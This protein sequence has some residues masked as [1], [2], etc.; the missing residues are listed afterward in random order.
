[1]S[2]FKNISQAIK[3]KEIEIVFTEGTDVRILAA[4]RKLRQE[5]LVKPV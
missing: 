5:G 1:M 2:I 4:A 3:G